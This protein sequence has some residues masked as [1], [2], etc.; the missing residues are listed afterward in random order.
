MVSNT[1]I[2][3]AK[4][5]TTFPNADEHMAIQ[6]SEIDLED[7]IPQGAI[8]LKTL[9]LSVDPYMRG[10]MRDPDAESYAPGFTLNEPMSGY[11][12]ASVAKSNNDKFKVDD[13]VYG[14]SAF[15]EYALVPESDTTYFEVRND[16]KESGLPLTNYISVL[17]MPGMTAYVG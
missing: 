16:A 4:A 14:I 6:K 3:F 1:K 5:P 17:G 10:L 12:M 13:Y 7:E 11:V 9:C 8:L 15:A 2:I